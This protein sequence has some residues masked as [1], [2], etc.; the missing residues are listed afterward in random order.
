MLNK[1]I[2]F[3]K[4]LKDIKNSKYL[5]E[6]FMKKLVVIDMQNDFV[7][8]SLGS[9]AAKAVVPRA[10]EK[11]KRYAADGAPIIC[12]LDTHG[13]NYAETREGKFLPVPHC[14][15]DT[16]GYRLNEKVLEA[17]AGAAESKLSFI[18][19]SAF[20]TLEWGK[21]VNDGDEIE[22]VGLCTDIC[23]V[24]NALIL[25]A[26]FPEMKITVDAACCA[27]SS[28]EAHDAA[29]TVMRSCQIEIA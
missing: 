29:L 6:V 26:M 19:K 9:E 5:L 25:K 16:L 18:K 12:T 13:K 24:S 28:K 17:L 20:G 2:I 15:E 21:F 10:A 11:I 8:G 27:G 14:I 4:N 3:A 23:V 7:D 1:K 22:L